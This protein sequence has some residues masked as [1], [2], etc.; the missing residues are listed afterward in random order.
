MKSYNK[1]KR[2]RGYSFWWVLVILV[3]FGGCNIT[4]SEVTKTEVSG[5][6]CKIIVKSSSRSEVLGFHDDLKSLSEQLFNDVQDKQVEGSYFDDSTNAFMRFPYAFVYG[7]FKDFDCSTNK[8]IMSAFYTKD[9]DTLIRYDLY[10]GKDFEDIDLKVSFNLGITYE[11]GNLKFV[12]PLYLNSKKYNRR[13]VGTIIFFYKD[14]ID[15]EE[16]R[17]SDD[18]SQK[19]ASLFKMAPIDF[20]YFKNNTMIESA[21]FD[22]FNYVYFMY[23]MDNYGGFSDIWNDNIIAGNGSAYFP[24]EIVHLYSSKLSG[25]VNPGRWFAEGIATLYGGA[26]GLN[27]SD[28]LCVLKS[29]IV[30]NKIR[31]EDFVMTDLPYLFGRKSRTSYVVG[32]ILCEMAIQKGGISK[33]QEF[34]KYERTE[35]GLYQAIQDVL[36]KDKKSINLEVYTYVLSQLC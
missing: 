5:E 36:G 16:A 13:K 33:Y 3:L 10:E 32:A 9:Q 23:N 26:M 29:Y 1:Y 2:L 7:Y 30:D 11:R 25:Y 4:E 19:M 20:K 34:L 8:V 18:F 21:H 28:Q 22:G 27:F 6:D 17:R 12:H 24:H 35:K 15:L 31:E 14:S